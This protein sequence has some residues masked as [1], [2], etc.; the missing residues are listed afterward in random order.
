MPAFI[1]GVIVII[2]TGAAA[3]LLYFVRRRGGEN[4]LGPQPEPPDRPKT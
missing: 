2:V 3:T 4:R 1:I